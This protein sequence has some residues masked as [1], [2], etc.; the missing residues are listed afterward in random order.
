MASCIPVRSSCLVCPRV[1]IDHGYTLP[2]DFA[3][4]CFE[5]LYWPQAKAPFDA[6]TRAYIAALDAAADLATLEAHGLRLSAGCR[7]VFAASTLLLR[8]GAGRG[9]SPHAIG[10]VMCREEVSVACSRRWLRRQCPPWLRCFVTKA[11]N[12]TPILAD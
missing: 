5:W 10:R 12:W 7:R 8:K 9:L 4:V 2:S 3:D 1:Q 11:S 6:A